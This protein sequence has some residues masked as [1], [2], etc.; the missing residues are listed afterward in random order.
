MVAHRGGRGGPRGRGM[1]GGMFRGRGRGG[2]NRGRGGFNGQPRN[3][4]F[5]P[6]APFDLEHCAT[7]FPKVSNTE[8]TD[9]A[10]LGELI[11]ERNKDLM[12]TQGA[13]GALEELFGEIKQAIE[14]IM[15]AVEKP[16][17][18]EEETGFDEIRKVGA[19]SNETVIEGVREFELLIQMKTPPKPDDLSQLAKQLQEKLPKHTVATDME[20]GEIKIANS[21]GNRAACFVTCVGAR[22]KTATEDNLAKKILYKNFD[23]GKRSR[24]FEE[25][26]SDPNI[27]VLARLLADLRV[28]FKGFSGLTQWAVELLSHY[29]I[30]KF[31]ENGTLTSLTIQ[32]AFRRC[33]MLL[34]SGFFLPGSAGIRDP[35]ERDGRSVHQNFSKNDQDMIC[36]TSQTLLRVLMQGAPK[37]VLGLESANVCEEMQVIDGIVVQ[38]SLGCYVDEEDHPVKMET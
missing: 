3:S 32:H 11:L 36:A 17:E 29:C 9:E 14:T 24:W 15:A 33:L 26:C 31:D 30:T 37:K 8:S 21:A 38:P 5:I 6:F 27:K 19:F 20:C 16:A 10:K 13:T 28:R 18:G 22:I 25:H 1:R 2:F 12:P 23:M 7:H 35:T 4:V 34:S